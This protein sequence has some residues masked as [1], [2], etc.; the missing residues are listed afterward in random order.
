MTTDVGR[1]PGRRMERAVAALLIFGVAAS[2]I[3]YLPLSVGGWMAILPVILLPVLRS[4][5]LR[6]V[7]VLLVAAGVV[8]LGADIGLAVPLESLAKGAARFAGIL[9]PFI[10][11]AW[12]IEKRLLDTHTVAL[13]HGTGWLIGVAIFFES[14]ADHGL[15]KFG[16]LAPVCFILVALISLQWKRTGSIAW[17]FCLGPVA[18]VALAAETRSVALQAGLALLL[19]LT[20]MR[21][22]SPWRSVV[23]AALVVTAFVFTFSMAANMGLLG[24]SIRDKW[25]NQ[26]GTVVSNVIVGRSESSFSVAAL[27]AEAFV[28]HGSESSVTR[29]AY[30]AGSKNVTAL[31]PPEKNAMLDRITSRGLDLH[32]VI[33]T[34]TWQGGVVCGGAY[35]LVMLLVLRRTVTL[36][37]GDV[38]AC[39]PLLIYSGISIVWDLIFSPWTYFTGTTCGVMLAILMAT[40]NAQRTASDTG[41]T[42]KR[43]LARG[44]K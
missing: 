14:T 20:L 27:S 12:A 11:C 36:Q 6:T 41:E 33:A 26:G 5:T 39:G 25:Q 35:A 22:T 4:R 32:S 13:L 16:L 37:R 7:V 43:D 8:Q 23:P 1:L 38:A 31:P 3:P 18:A 42:M 44:M 10:G 30:S 29:H 2:P 21:I 34:A 9:L 24:E 40:V 28:P 19:C 15:W 17:L